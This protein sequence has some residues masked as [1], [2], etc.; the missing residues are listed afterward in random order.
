MRPFSQSRQLLKLDQLSTHVASYAPNGAS[1]A[2]NVAS[3]VQQQIFGPTFA[4]V[5]DLWKW[6]RDDACHSALKRQ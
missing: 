2:P 5:K 1:C 6:K 3:F 4:E